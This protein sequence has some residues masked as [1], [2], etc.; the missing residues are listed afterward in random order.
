VGI[1]WCRTGDRSI[2]GQ[3]F[4]HGIAPF[5]CRGGAELGSLSSQVTLQVDRAIEILKGGG[6]IA[7]PTDTVYGLGSDVFNIEAAERIYR[8]KQRPRHL[9]LPVLLADSTQLASTVDSVSGIAQ[10]LIRRFWPG[11]LTLVLPKRS[12]LPD[13]ITAGSNKVAVRV[14]GHVVPLALIRGLGAPIIGTSANVSDKPSPVTAEE[15]EQ[16]L[17]SQIDL[18]VDMGKCPGGLESTV[19]DVT[20]GTPVILR[21]GIIPE[22]EI[23]KACQEYARE[24]GKSAHCSG[25]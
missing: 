6:V 10:F 25:L 7:F 16:Q 8:V 22:K 24:V 13:I 3:E 14:P 20:G 18:I 11:G 19:V 9:P 4:Q 15:V 2:L 23:K 1:S 17:G 5:I 21:R 12:L